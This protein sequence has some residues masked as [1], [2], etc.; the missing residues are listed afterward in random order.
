[1]PRSFIGPLGIV[2]AIEA[3]VFRKTVSAS[4]VFSV[5]RY[6]GLDISRVLRDYILPPSSM[7][8]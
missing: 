7:A 2:I 3:T 5:A 1:M 4:N 6:A 8:R